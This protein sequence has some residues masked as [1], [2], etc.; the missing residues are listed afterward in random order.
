M[1]PDSVTTDLIKA[2]TPNFKLS[3]L[4]NNLLDINIMQIQAMRENRF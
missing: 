2:H 1:T 3:L 4:L